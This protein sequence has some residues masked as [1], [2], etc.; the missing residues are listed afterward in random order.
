LD[1]LS[2][3]KQKPERVFIVHGEAQAADVFRV[4]LK[5]TYGWDA[6]IAELNQ[7]ITL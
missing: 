3:I 4:K 6:E 7:I 2:N 5:D 1:W